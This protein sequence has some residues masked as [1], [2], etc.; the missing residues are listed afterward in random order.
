M[1]GYLSRPQNL[2]TVSRWNSCSWRSYIS[3]SL[4]EHFLNL[5]LILEQLL[6]KISSSG[7]LLLWIRVQVKRGLLKCQMGA[8]VSCLADDTSVSESI[9]FVNLHYHA[10]LV[11]LD[12]FWL[13]LVLSRWSL[14]QLLEARIFHCWLRLN[15]HVRIYK[16]I[17]HND[18]LLS[19]KRKNLWK[20][21]RIESQVRLSKP[22]TTPV[23][24]NVLTNTLQVDW[25]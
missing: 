4:F 11:C 10:I 16:S 21:R 17:F 18:C 13:Q 8:P 1:L 3:Q 12:L 19:F 14:V 15:C 2:N 24:S 25:P 7:E 23:T 20:I 22:V 9:V 5:A 6:D